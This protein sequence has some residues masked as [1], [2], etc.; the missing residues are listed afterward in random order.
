MVRMKLPLRRRSR[1]L[2][3]PCRL[4][5]VP[6]FLVRYPPRRLH[7]LRDRARFLPR[8]DLRVRRLLRRV[9]C[10]GQR[11]RELHPLDLR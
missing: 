5:C 1:V 2:R 10:L 8:R 3:C 7:G 6:L 11:L 9:L 4:R